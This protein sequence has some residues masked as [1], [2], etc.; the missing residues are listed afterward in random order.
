MGNEPLVRSMLAQRS[1]CSE[2]SCTSDFAPINMV[3]NSDKKDR[4]GTQLERNTLLGTS[5]QLF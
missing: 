3:K 4:V 2:V 1:S 5:I